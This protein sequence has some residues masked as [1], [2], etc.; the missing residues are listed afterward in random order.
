[1]RDAKGK[2][3]GGLAM[4]VGAPGSGGSDEDEDMIEDGDYDEGSGPSDEESV[5][6]EDILAAVRSRDADGLAAALR[7][8]VDAC[9]ASRDAD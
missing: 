1:M 5:A 8:F 9:M 6:A 2:G 7:D 3:V 4:L